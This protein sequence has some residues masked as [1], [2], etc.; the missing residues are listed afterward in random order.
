MFV[1]QTTQSCLQLLKSEEPS[2]PWSRLEL[3]NASMNTPGHLPL[4]V[5]C[6]TGVVCELES[7]STLPLACGEKVSSSSSMH[8]RTYRFN[9]CKKNAGIKINS[10]NQ[11]WEDYVPNK[12]ANFSYPVLSSK[13]R[14]P[15]GLS[16]GT[17]TNHIMN[18]THLKDLNH[19]LW[20]KKWES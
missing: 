20:T 9:Q 12:A 5:F 6:L 16:G 17:A 7:R 10:C 14:S 4:T 13:S 18:F 15:H 11:S 2:G 8:K 19:T 3:L 1:T